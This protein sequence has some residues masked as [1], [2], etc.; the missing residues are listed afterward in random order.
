MKKNH[1]VGRVILFIV[2]CFIASAVCAGA[3]VNEKDARL[4]QAAEKGLLPEI[5]FSQQFFHCT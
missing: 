3:V 5:S 4:I 1:S 2:G